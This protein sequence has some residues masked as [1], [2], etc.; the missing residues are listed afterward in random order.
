MFLKSTITGRA[1]I[2]RS[3]LRSKARNC[4]HSVAITTASASSAALIGAFAIGHVGQL[5]SRLLHPGRIVAA[6]PRAHVGQRG[7][8][9]HRRRIAG[10]VG[11][12]LKRQA[13]HGNGRPADRTFQRC[14]DFARHGPLALLVDRGDG[15]DD[16]QLRSVIVGGLEQRGRI[17][18]ETRAAEA[19]TGMEK[20]R[21]DPIIEAHAARHLLHV[22]AEALAQIGNFVDERYLGG[23]KGIG[24]VFDQFSGSPADI[25][26]RRG[27]EIK[28]TIYFSEHR[29]RLTHPRCPPRC[30]RDA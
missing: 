10:I 19:R 27:V 13:K 26:D 25:E 9:R 8:Q 22:S 4:S 5:Q 30:G 21:P 28:R 2:R 6:H 29:A 24:G 16:A 18:G 14:G 12:R 1:I 15:L 7:N 3:R 11:V 23:E 20:F 17:L